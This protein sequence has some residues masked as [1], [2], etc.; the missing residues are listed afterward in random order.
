M[1]VA[2]FLGFV[3]GGE[4]ESPATLR[5]RVALLE[6]Q[7]AALAARTGTDLSRVKPPCPVSDRVRALIAQG[8]TIHAVKAHREETG[9]GLKEA[10]DDVDDVARG[11]A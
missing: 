8:K 1:G 5:R 6:A 9:L 3:D 7:V 4:G 11:N 2:E 10:K